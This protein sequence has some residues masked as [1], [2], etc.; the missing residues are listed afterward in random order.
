M[1]FHDSRVPTNMPMEFALNT[2]STTFF[3]NCPNNGIRIE[4]ALTIET[5]EVFRVEEILAVVDE[6]N[7]GFH[8]EIADSLLERFKGVQTLIANHHGVIIKTVRA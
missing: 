4:Y 2:Y 3:C 6:Y 5:R 8:E 7:E 1:G